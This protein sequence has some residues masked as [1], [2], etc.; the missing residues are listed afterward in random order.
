MKNIINCPF[1]PIAKRV[2]SHRGAQGVM[3]GSMIG[4]KYGECD[5]NYGGEIE[6]HNEYDSLWVYHGND[7]SGG[8]NMF[9]GV[10]GFPYVQ[11]TV[12]F[13]KFK[14]RVYSIA[15]DFPPYHEMVKSKL[16]SAKK[17]VQ[18]EWHDVDLDNLERMFNEAETIKYPNP[19]RKLVI[20]DSHSICMYRPGWTVNSVPFK[21]LNGALNDGLS[22]YI[23][24]DVDEV[25]CYFGNIDIRHHVCRLDIDPIALA[26]RYIEEVKQLPVPAKIYELL[27]IEN[28]S[29]K[30]PQSGYYKGKPFY[31]TWQERTDARNKFNDR[32][33]SKYGLIRWTDHL[34]NEQGELDFAC[35]EKPQSIHL[36][37]EFYPHWNGLAPKNSLEE[38][39]V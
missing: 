17:E 2:A 23:D 24:L 7:W 10:Y 38:F 33:E 12:N 6:D 29:R 18:P 34:L 39:F 4:E 1:I 5:V 37:R 25:E 13:S 27:P 14:G 15:I 30:I 3:Y 8:I 11:N 35:M 36:S 20:G 22:T 28:E 26:D 19:T 21:T 32:I 31:G 16:E 9:G